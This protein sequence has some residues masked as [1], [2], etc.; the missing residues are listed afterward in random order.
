VYSKIDNKSNAIINLEYFSKMCNMKKYYNLTFFVMAFDLP[1][2][3]FELDE[4][5]PFI[6]KETLE[7]HY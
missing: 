3:P 2:L 1:K 4:L 7:Y 5:E 6:S